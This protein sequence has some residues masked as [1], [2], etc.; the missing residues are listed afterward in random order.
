[1]K[2]DGHS[3]CLTKVS[4]HMIYILQ[5]FNT[6]TVLVFQHNL[7][8]R[9]RA[10]INGAK[11]YCLSLPETHVRLFRHPHSWEILQSCS[12]AFFAWV[13]SFGHMKRIYIH[14]CE[15]VYCYVV[16]ITSPMQ[17]ESLRQ[18]GGVLGSCEGNG[19]TKGG[20]ELRGNPQASE[21]GHTPQL[22]WGPSRSNLITTHIQ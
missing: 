18:R 19:K 13:V 21:T 22:F 10:K 15:W 16:H 6:S 4:F 3:P 12:V 9:P 7:S 20:A 14:I 5:H 8:P 17:K 2:L 1:M 11:A